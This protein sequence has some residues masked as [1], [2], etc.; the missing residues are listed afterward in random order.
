MSRFQLRYTFQSQ[1]SIKTTDSKLIKVQCYKIYFSLKTGPIG[2]I[3]LCKNINLQKKKKIYLILWLFL[4]W[5][6]PLKLCLF[7]FAGQSLHCFI[8]LRSKERRL[9]DFAKKITICDF[10]EQRTKALWFCR[11]KSALLYNFAE[12]CLHCLLFL[13]DKEMHS[14]AKIQQKNSLN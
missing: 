1:S 3:D 11:A 4:L 6:L 5:F 10:A 12:L 13:Q 2:C 9:C 7:D 8:I 14:R